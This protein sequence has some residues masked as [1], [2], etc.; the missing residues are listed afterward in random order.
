MN[1]LTILAVLLTSSGLVVLA[2]RTSLQRVRAESQRLIRQ[3]ALTRG[4][5]EEAAGT[6]ADLTRTL[7]EQRNRHAELRSRLEFEAQADGAIPLEPEREGLWPVGKPYFYLN[8]KYLV[9]AL[10]QKFRGSSRGLGLHP[11]TTV[12]LG[13]TPAEA[14]TIEKGFEDLVARFKDLEKA[15][16]EPSRAHAIERWPGKKKTS[17][18]MPPL[19]QEMEPAIANYFSSVRS[20]LGEARAALFEGWAR[21]CIADSAWDFAPKARLFTLTDEEIRGDQRLTRFEM[22]EESGKSLY[23][24]ELWYPPGD[25]GLPEGARP[26][27]PYWHLFGETGEKRPGQLLSR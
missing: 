19:R 15:R 16:L 23:Y 2:L 18:R 20:T 9:D 11:D 7:E 6:V 24:F 12:A 13:M 27:F 26:R 8:K 21:H 22:A 4:L 17:Y 1:N 25:Y 14:V 5:T 10:F 3:V